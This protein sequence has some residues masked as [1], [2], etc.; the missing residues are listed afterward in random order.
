MALGTVL[1]TRLTETR[2]QRLLVI[3]NCTE[4]RPWQMKDDV[5]PKY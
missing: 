2:P 3:Q 1:G 5:S 4:M